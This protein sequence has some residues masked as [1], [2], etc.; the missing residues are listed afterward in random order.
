MITE[1]SLA[2]LK[3]PAPLTKAFKL[4]GARSLFQE[5]LRRISHFSK[6]NYG[7]LLAKREPGSQLWICHTGKAAKTL[8][9]ENLAK[10]LETL[11]NS[12]VRKFVLAIGDAD[13]FQQS[14]IQNIHP[15]F[16]WSFGPMTLP[17]ELAAVVAAEQI[18]RAWTILGGLPYHKGH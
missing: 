8:T 12:G 6:T 3:S 2:W 9:S 13:G 17:H 7:P 14:E 10:M 4:E 18:Y 16:V 5:Y 1:F 11:R 15:D